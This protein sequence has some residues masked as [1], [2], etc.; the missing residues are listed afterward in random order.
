MSLQ[1]PPHACQLCEWITCHTLVSQHF[2]GG[3][4]SVYLLLHQC[5]E[6]GLITLSTQHNNVIC[7]DDLFG[8][9]NG[10]CTRR[11]ER[12]QLDLV[13]GNAEKLIPVPRN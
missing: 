13:V 6:Q 2:P 11:Q 7:V 1:E 12:K 9:G 8:V 4:G 10:C 3:V 5:M